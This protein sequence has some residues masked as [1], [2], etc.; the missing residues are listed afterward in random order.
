ML[1][2]VMN[3]EIDIQMEFV[4][5]EDPPTVSIK[6][7]EALPLSKQKPYIGEEFFV[8][9]PPHNSKVILVMEVCL[10]LQEPNHVIRKVFSIEKAITF[11]RSNLKEEEQDTY[12]RGGIVTNSAKDDKL[13]DKIAKE[14]SRFNGKY[15]QWV[16]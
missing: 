5:G 7:L 14:M 6:A 9:R 8:L 4:T 15:P 10:N 12:I 3:G 2:D 16:D 11:I 13:R 1:S